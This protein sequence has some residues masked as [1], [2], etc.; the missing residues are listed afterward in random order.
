MKVLFIINFLFL[1]YGVTLGEFCY[2]G[3][4]CD[5]KI[6]SG[7]YMLD[8]TSLEKEL[9][10][11]NPSCLDIKNGSGSVLFLNVSNDEDG[12]VS[13][14]WTDKA[15]QEEE[16]CLVLHLYTHEAAGVITVKSITD[17]T[18]S[19]LGNTTLNQNK[20]WQ[21]VTIRFKNPNRRSRISVETNFRQAVGIL[22]ISD[23]TIS[24]QCAKSQEIKSCPGSDQFPCGDNTCVP[25]GKV[26]DLH[27][28]CANGK[29]EQMCDKLPDP[30]VCT[31]ENGMCGW[32]LGTH[33]DGFSWKRHHGPKPPS[34]TGPDTDHTLGTADGYYMHIDSGPPSGYYDP[35]ILQSPV[36][37]AIRENFKRACKLRFFYHMLGK[38]MNTLDIQAIDVC[39]KRKTKLWSKSGQQGD[40][41]K[42]A[43]IS[44]SNISQRYIINIEGYGAHNDFGDIAV[45]DISFSPECFG[46]SHDETSFQSIPCH[47]KPLTIAEFKNKPDFYCNNDQVHNGTCP[48]VNQFACEDKSCVFWNQV[49]NLKNDCSNGRDEQI[50]DDLPDPAR[51]TFE[52]GMCGWRER[53]HVKGFSWK[54]QRGPTAPSGTGPD[55][56]HTKGTVDGESISL[57]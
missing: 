31:F 49:C 47:K 53:T 25:W 51:C 9:C 36:M 15:L 24:Y 1:L 39:L 13:N 34:G 55:V 26:C 42:F 54:L 43:E 56:D 30:A 4:E 10:P 37:P 33:Y 50:C 44:L 40:E 6:Q 7:F 5:W 22:I 18:E 19:T 8:F 20:R 32:K 29:D 52:D 28:D 14:Q 46:I 16:S 48:G 57:N 38:D 12:I 3:E 11:D 35:A 2:S 23:I 27:D 41:W 45:D 21:D 17:T